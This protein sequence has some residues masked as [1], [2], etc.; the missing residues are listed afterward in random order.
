MGKTLGRLSIGV[1]YVGAAL[2]L[3]DCGPAKYTFDRDPKDATT[4]GD[5]R[6]S[7][8]VTDVTDSSV[9]VDVT[10][11]SVVPDIT[12]SSVVMDITDS[13][14]VT[15]VAD[16]MD[17]VD[18]SDVRIEAAIEAAVCTTGQTL[19]GP[20]CVNLITN[21]EHCGGCGQTCDLAHAATQRCS[22]STCTVISCDPGWNNCDAMNSNGCELADSALRSNAT[23]CGRCGN[24]CATDQVCEAGACVAAQR[25]CRSTGAPG[26]GVVMVPG[27]TF[28]M[29]DT[30]A[31]NASPVQP[32]Q[33]VSPFLIDRYEVTVARFRR[34][35]DAGHPAVP[36]GV[37]AYP[38]N[39]AFP[40]TG[41]IRAPFVGGL[42]NWSTDAGAIENHPVNFLTWATSQ[43]FCVWDGG[44]LPT[45]AEWEFA[46]RGTDGRPF[47][48]GT[49]AGSDLACVYPPEMRATTC[50]EDDTAFLSGA[51][52]WGALH[53][54]GNVA[55]YCADWY[56]D[57]GSSCWRGMSA[58]NPICGDN[59]RGAHV[60]RGGS[61]LAS[62]PTDWRSAS[63]EIDSGFGLIAVSGFRCVRT[64]L[65]LVL[66]RR[67]TLFAARSLR[68]LKPH[69]TRYSRPTFQFLTTSFSARSSFLILFF[70]LM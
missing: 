1:C 20:T 54:V 56:A 47:P 67:S 46:A 3:I 40:S 13:S 42:G 11:S 39:P 8:V 26:C 66:L 10:D 18:V 68:D 69:G 50:A 27:G 24:A 48:W 4:K 12:D 52:P 34:F 23:H 62:D 7:S 2:W 59:S 51:S 16:A 17:V 45:E 15:D 63:R 44:R 9:V 29:G 53:M 21:S 19:C 55:E 28:T 60:I 33:T 14:V 32:G 49:R 58:N 41:I 61:R 36:G 22:A 65:R 6:D 5:V 25:S 37:V 57:Y 38:G 43:A 31:R 35:W 70:T 64:S 30:G